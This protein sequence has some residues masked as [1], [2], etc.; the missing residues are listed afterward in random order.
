MDDHVLETQIKNSLTKDDLQ[1]L[2]TMN[3]E[4]IVKKINEFSDKKDALNF[5]WGNMQELSSRETQLMI[6]D[7]ILKLVP[8]LAIS[9]LPL[10]ILTQDFSNEQWIITGII[11]SLIGL[12][13]LI[14]YYGRK[15]VNYRI[16]EIGWSND[17]A[18]LKFD[19]LPEKKLN[20]DRFL[21]TH[22]GKVNF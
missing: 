21:N 18:K 3:R 14:T 5:I 6:A 2:L 7:S 12:I 8:V 19:V 17:Y 9:S 11:Y 13:T 10:L 4:I 15:W 22:T 20:S 16:L 1:F